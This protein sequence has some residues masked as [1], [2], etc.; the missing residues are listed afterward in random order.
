MHR[1]G[2]RRLRDNPMLLGA[3]M[4]YLPYP[5]GKLLYLAM[6]VG[7]LVLGLAGLVVGFTG[8]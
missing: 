3:L 7:I 8:Q 1:D 6:S 4:G 5:V 2:Q